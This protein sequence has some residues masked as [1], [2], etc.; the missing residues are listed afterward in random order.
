[1]SSLV[2][3][4]VCTGI[5][6]YDNGD[7]CTNKYVHAVAAFNTPLI[8]VLRRQVYPQP[9]F[10]NECST[11]VRLG[12][13]CLHHSTHKIIYTCIQWAEVFPRRSLAP[14][15]PSPR[16]L[17]TEAFETCFSTCPSLRSCAGRY[18][19]RHGL[20]MR[21]KESKPGTFRSGPSNTNPSNYQ[22][23]T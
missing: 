5:Q 22:C 13:I 6:S 16:P 4:I 10:C 15:H 21:L 17:N 14:Q 1:M 8:A 2:L 20:A 12:S 9:K 18:I 11:C 3:C 7:Q 23:A 19:R